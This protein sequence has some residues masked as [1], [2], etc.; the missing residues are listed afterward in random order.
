MDALFSQ[1]DQIDRNRYRNAA[2]KDES[3]ASGK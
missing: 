3:I 1:E 2:N